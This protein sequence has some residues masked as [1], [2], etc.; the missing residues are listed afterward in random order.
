M[1]LKV[2]SYVDEKNKICLSSNAIDIDV[3]DLSWVAAYLC[4]LIAIKSNQSLERVCES[5]IKLATKLVLR[6]GAK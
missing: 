4:R 6:R 1:H 2:I 3:I 5:I